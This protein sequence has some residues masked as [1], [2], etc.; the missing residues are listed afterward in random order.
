M[1]T[2]LILFSSN[3]GTL[4]SDFNSKESTKTDLC[5]ETWIFLTYHL[6]NTSVKRS[7]ELNHLEP[8]SP[9]TVFICNVLESSE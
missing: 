3:N 8:F 5:I 9:S 1:S 7:K 6:S 4:V 2:L